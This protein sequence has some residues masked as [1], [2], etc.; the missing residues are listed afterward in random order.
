MKSLARVCVCV[1]VKLTRAVQSRRV[2]IEF[3]LMLEHFMTVI[4]RV[5]TMS[6][7]LI[8]CCCCRRC[9][10]Q[11]HRYH[12]R[13]RALMCV[14]VRRS[15]ERFRANPAGVRLRGRVRQ[16]M[17]GQVARLAKG[18]VANVAHERFLAGMNALEK[19][20]EKAISRAEISYSS[21]GAGVNLSKRLLRADTRSH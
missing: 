20:D 8:G 19:A 5:W 1:K 18:A 15:I 4:A 17:S 12:R 14:K 3:E 16:L 7:A 9:C 10:F 13:V 21:I 6:I 11:R 2:Q